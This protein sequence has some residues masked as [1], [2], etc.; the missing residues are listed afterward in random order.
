MRLASFV[1]FCNKLSNNTFATSPAFL[2]VFF[3][4]SFCFDEAANLS[5]FRKANYSVTS[6]FLCLPLLLRPDSIDSFFQRYFHQSGCHNHSQKS[7]PIS[8]HRS[9]S[10]PH[11][12]PAFPDCRQ[13]N[14]PAATNLTRVGNLLRGEQSRT[15]TNSHEQIVHNDSGDI[16]KAEVALQLPRE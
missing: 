13:R 15:V 3:F 4:A 11:L 7:P 9:S 16:T 2:S 12:P 10:F 6:F 1:N 5:G 8:Q 14:H